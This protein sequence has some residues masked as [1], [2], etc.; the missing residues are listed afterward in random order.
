SKYAPQF[1]NK[2]GEWKLFSTVKEEVAMIIFAD[3]FKKIGK[4]KENLAYYASHRLEKA[5]ND[6]LVMIKKN[7]EEATCLE[8]NHDPILN[9]FQLVKNE[10][11]IKRSTKD[12]WMKNQVFMMLPGSWSPVYVPPDGNVSFFYFEKIE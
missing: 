5:A 11:L 10:C 3:L 12:E 8:G 4:G 6:A 1:Q 9:Q 7:Q 2:E